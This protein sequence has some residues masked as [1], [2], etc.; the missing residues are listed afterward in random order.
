MKVFK[1]LAAA[2]LTAALALSMIVVPASAAPGSFTDVSDP[3]TAVNADILRLMGVVS[4][5]GDNR[6]NP[7]GALTR[8]QFC[9]MVVTFLQRGDEAPRYGTRTIFSD[10]RSDHWARSYVNLAASISVTDSDGENSTSIPL[11]SGVGDGRFLPDDN[12]SMAEASTILLR[13]LGYTARRPAP[14]G[15][16]ATWTWP[17]P[18]ACLRGST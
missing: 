12:I 9:T 13:A 3:N 2:L 16:R 15:P 11:V 10:V 7:S 4:G 8:A 14:Y 1:R 6:F 5:T 17:S 18:P